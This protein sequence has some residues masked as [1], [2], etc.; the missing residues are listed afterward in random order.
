MTK[1]EALDLALE[2]LENWREFDPENFGEIDNKAITA[3]KQAR[4]AP[5]Q[6]PVAW[7][8][9]LKRNG[10]FA[11]VSTEYS[12]V[13]LSIGENW[14]PLYTTP[15]AAQQ[16]CNCRWDGE[17]QVQQCTLHEAH[18]DAIHE[19]A[20]RAKAAEAKLKAQPAP[21]QEAAALEALVMICVKCRS[22]EWGP[23]TPRKE[24]L[25]WFHDFASKALDDAAPPAAQRQW[26]GLTDEEVM[27]T[28]SG[29]WTSQFYFARAI[30]A[31]LKEKNT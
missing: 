23:D 24:I 26:V 22:N 8:Y 11:G 15:P 5:V 29:D 21:V 30:E 2:A 28:M 12:P 1:D 20:E 13:K 19:W 3:I 27:Q 4:S 31:K 6:E 9:D 25:N 10:S 16:T 7:R 17:V 18:V 14:T